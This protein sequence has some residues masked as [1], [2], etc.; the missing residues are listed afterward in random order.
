MKCPAC[1][2]EIADSDKFVCRACWHKVPAKDRVQFVNMWVKRID[3][4]S[5]LAKI[6]RELKAKAGVGSL[7]L[8][9][10]GPDLHVDIELVEPRRE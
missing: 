2:G 6:V 5:K 9:N 10:N 3:V 4:T 8:E 7:R 1:S